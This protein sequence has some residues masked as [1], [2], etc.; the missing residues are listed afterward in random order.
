MGKTSLLRRWEREGSINPCLW[1]DLDQEIEKQEGRSISE[2]FEFSG[3]ESFRALE[4]QVL[5]ALLQ[6]KEK[7]VIAVGAGFSWKDF[8]FPVDRELVEILWV[9]RPT[10]SLGRIFFDRPKLDAR[11][12]DLKEY[13]DN[14]EIRWEDYNSMANRIYEL[15]EGLTEAGEIE[16]AI[17]ENRIAD[18]S[19]ILT[20]TP[21]N[22]TWNWSGRIELRTD[23]WTPTQLESFQF[24]EV[25]WAIRD[26]VKWKELQDRF[27]EQDWID[28]ALELGSPPSIAAKNLILSLHEIPPGESL[29]SALARLTSVPAWH[30]KFSPKVKSWS[31]LESGW[32]WQQ[33]D[34]SRRSFLPRSSDGRWRWYRLWAKAHQRINFVQDGASPFIEQPTFYEWLSTPKSFPF[35]AAVLGDPVIHSRSPMEQGPFFKQKG[36]PFWPILVEKRDWAQALPFLRKLGLRAAA[37]TSP[38]KRLFDPS[39]SLNTIG[40]SESG[41]ISVANTDQSGLDQELGSFRSRPAV[42]WGGG[43]TLSSIQGTL[44]QAFSYSVRTG[45]SRSP[46]SIENPE[47]L[48]WAAG[49]RDPSPRDQNLHFWRPQVVI[50]LNY[51]ED[52]AARSYAKIVEAR[53]ISGEGLFKRQAAGQREFWKDRI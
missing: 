30:Y 52:S 19:G 35:F 38:L 23:W 37:V 1:V 25:L 31:D 40:W 24:A 15:P 22:R 50:D 14:L 18:E 17:L 49:P 16:A 12:S 43:G 21:Q 7:M 34:P 46:A 53:Y 47:I 41:E 20:L 33:R 32:N 26:P 11:K 13:L 3:Q 48:V 51:R 10:D 42:I 9:R 44:P 27:R 5:A 6:R 45:Q 2:I 8:T 36:A 4:R 29:D 28:W 39:R